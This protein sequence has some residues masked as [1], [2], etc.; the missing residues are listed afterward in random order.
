MTV[1]ELA[2]LAD[3]M[4]RQRWYVGKDAAPRLRLLTSIEHPCDDL[5]ARVRTLIVADDSRSPAVVYQVPVVE[6]TR[7]HL[8]G[9]ADPAYTTALHRAL[10]GGGSV[11]E[12]L[13][14]EQS[15]TSIVYRDRPPWICKVFRV[16]QP[17]PS[18]EVELQ[19]ALSE[20][21]CPH[22]PRVHGGLSGSWP[23]PADPDRLV[24]GTLCVAQEYVTGAAE[25]W[26]LAVGA[27][28]AGTDFGAAAAELGETTAHVH[29]S[30]ARAFDTTPAGETQ[31]ARILRGWQE[32][33]D[34]AARAV[35]E[36]APQVA[37]VAER[38]EHAAASW[39]PALQRV[40]G[41]LHLGQTILSP[42]R[43]WLLID[44]EGEPL[45]PAAERSAPDL[46][47][48]DV[49]GMLRSFDYAH[50]AAGAAGEWARSAARGFLRGYAAASGVAVNEHAALL[51]ALQL[52][53][54]V[55]E[56]Q[57]EATTRPDWVS[58]PL[59]G[60]ARLVAE[61]PMG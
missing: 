23:D 3:W 8:D 30:L 7:L 61:S 47:L 1:N 13:V 49:A 9:A 59:A 16:L 34:Q 5:A 17:G 40:H 28:A 11:G 48:R 39:W 33:L 6:R 57:Y 54:A 29:A 20:A 31:R 36:L 35:P 18:A 4:P 46:A 42:D 37:P 44:F 38:F 12:V 50:S 14:A 24:T 25:G 51:T 52:D 19:S 27:A 60:I 45:R 26:R 2:L 10:G 32:R 43:G 55:Y 58:I 15:N 41:D 53:K 21:D 22:V 56:V